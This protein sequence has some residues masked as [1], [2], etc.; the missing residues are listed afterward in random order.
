MHASQSSFLRDPY[1]EWVAGEGI[2][3]LEGFGIRL[4]DAEIGLW[5]RMGGSCR[6]AAV[7]LSGRGDYI[8]AF[9]IE[10]PAG[11]QSDPQ[12]HLYESVIYVLSG[13]GSTS[14]QARGSWHSFEW[15]RGSLF[16]LPLNAPYRHFNGSGA[17]AARLVAVTNLPMMLNCFHSPAFVFDNQFEFADRWG[18]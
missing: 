15:S 9:L 2:S 6:G 13:R 7:H 3:S 10:L 18:D 8:S 17:E 4:L 1:L 12:R 5:P 11:G 16:A 14:I